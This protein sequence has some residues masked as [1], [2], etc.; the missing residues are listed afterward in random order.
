MELVKTCGDA[1]LVPVPQG[2]LDF[3]LLFADP[4]WDVMLRISPAE[5][6]AAGMPQTPLAKTVAD[7]R[8][9]DRERGEPPL[10]IGMSEE[11]E[12]T[13]LAQAGQN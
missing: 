1:D 8:A 3:P 7:T 4:A 13:A 2:E 10:T 11:E 5:A 12:R 9:W 6:L